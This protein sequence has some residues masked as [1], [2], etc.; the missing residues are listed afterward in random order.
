MK[1]L[2]NDCNRPAKI[3]GYCAKHYSLFRQR[4]APYTLNEIMIAPLKSDSLKR[5]DMTIE[6]RQQLARFVLWVRE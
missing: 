4:G 5:S 3:K 1:C 6:Q 2:R